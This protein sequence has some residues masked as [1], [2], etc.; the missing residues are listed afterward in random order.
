MGLNFQ[1]HGFL[2]PG[3]LFFFLSPGQSD[4]FIDICQEMCHPV[5]EE[6]CNGTKRVLSELNELPEGDLITI[7]PEL[8]SC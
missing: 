4:P 3:E 1:A 7:P 2:K 6:I 8:M 5:L